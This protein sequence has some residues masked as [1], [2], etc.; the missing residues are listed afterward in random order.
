MRAVAAAQFLPTRREL[1]L[2]ALLFV[3]LLCFVPSKYVSDSASLYFGKTG[4]LDGFIGDAEKNGAVRNDGVRGVSFPEPRM[5]WKET[6]PETE[7]L[8]HAPGELEGYSTRRPCS[9][10][11]F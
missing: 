5:S 3:G 2:L 11:L 9:L 7:V 1:V 8:H 4:V 6:I 10:I